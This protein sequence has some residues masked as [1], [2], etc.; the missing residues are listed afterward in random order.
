M[1][2]VCAFSGIAQ[3]VKKNPHNEKGIPT[4]IQLK[5]NKPTVVNYIMAVAPTPANFTGVRQ[6]VTEEN[7][8]VLIAES[9][10]SVKVPINV[11]FLKEGA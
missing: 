1:I 4:V 7:G 2:A 3:G 9:G 11:G 8:C 6:I 5:P 10:K